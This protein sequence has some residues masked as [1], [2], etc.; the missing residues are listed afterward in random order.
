MC[1]HPLFW[2]NQYGDLE[3]ALLRNGN[4]HSADVLDFLAALPARYAEP[5][6]IILKLRSNYGIMRL[7]VCYYKA[8][9]VQE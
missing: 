6:V 2:F 8:R 4:V 5:G 9:S 1:Y 7:E 3:R